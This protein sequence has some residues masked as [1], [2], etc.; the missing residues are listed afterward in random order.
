MLFKFVGKFGVLL[1]AAGA[2]D[3]VRL[4]NILFYISM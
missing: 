1:P 4:C 3:V 2:V